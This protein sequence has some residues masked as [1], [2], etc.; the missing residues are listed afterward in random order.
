MIKIKALNK[1]NLFKT[2]LI[3]GGSF[4]FIFILRFAVVRDFDAGFSLIISAVILFL[5]F[6]MERM[7]TY[8]KF[9]KKKLS[10]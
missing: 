5:Y 10:F 1:E 7:R 8:V 9:R 4:L 6:L 3:F 2:I